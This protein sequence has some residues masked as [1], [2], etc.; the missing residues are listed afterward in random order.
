[1]DVRPV[2]PEHLKRGLVEGMDGLVGRDLVGD[3]LQRR[4]GGDELSVDVV[5]IGLLHTTT[6][7][8]RGG[9][10]MTLRGG[11]PSRCSFTRGDARA[12]RS[13]S[14]ASTDGL[15]SSRSRTLPFTCT[16]MVTLS[17]TS[18]AASGWGQACSC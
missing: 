17:S 5:H 4:K 16:T 7:T 9:L 11:R 12:S 15:T 13:I 10:M 2:A 3:F 6:L 8:S 1:A 14:A 18:M